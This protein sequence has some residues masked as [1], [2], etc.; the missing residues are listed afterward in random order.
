MSCPHCGGKIDELTVI[1]S[2]CKKNVR[3]TKKQHKRLGL[4]WFALIVIAIFCI[5][6]FFGGRSSS[7]K[8]IDAIPI[9]ASPLQSAIEDALSRSNRGIE[10]VSRFTDGGN[11]SSQI[12]VEFTI[13]DNL[14]ADMIAGGAQIDCT[15]ILKTIALSGAQYGSVRIIGTFP[16]QDAFG[17]AEETDVVQVTYQA[18]TI[19]K[20]NW[21]SFQHKNVYIVADSATIHPLFQ[22]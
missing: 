17:N 1:C 4:G 7:R 13:N 22:R 8:K 14:S 6:I 21:A 2:H 12:V 5:P 16:V 15:T 18:A 11:A 20:I 9:S 10:R 3:K 19:Q